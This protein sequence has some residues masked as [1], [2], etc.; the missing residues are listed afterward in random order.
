ME[1]VRLGACGFVLLAGMIWLS[2]GA[3]AQGDKCRKTFEK[4]AFQ[5]E[6][7]SN[8]EVSRFRTDCPEDPST[9]DLN[10]YREN[11]KEQRRK[12][13]EA[14]DIVRSAADGLTK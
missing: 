6:N 1:I 10:R 14:V 7:P 12:I 4:L 9:K 2:G 3:E 5:P 13:A 8:E 11:I